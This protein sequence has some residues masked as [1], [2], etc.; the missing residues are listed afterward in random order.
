MTRRRAGFLPWLVL[1]IACAPRQDAQRFEKQTPMRWSEVTARW[2]QTAANPLQGTARLTEITEATGDTL[3]R[4]AYFLWWPG[5]GFRMHTGSRDGRP[6]TP[7]RYHLLGTTLTT[8]VQGV[9]YRESVDP[10]DPLPDYYDGLLIPLALEHPRG[11][12]TAGLAYQTW[13][14]PPSF[15]V[16]LTDRDPQE[17]G[18]Q[19]WTFDDE[20]GLPLRYEMAAHD[21]E[22]EFG[23][24]RTVDWDW[25]PGTALEMA[26]WGLAIRDTALGPEVTRAGE[27][28]WPPGSVGCDGEP[29]SRIRREHFMP[30][31]L[32]GTDATGAPLALTDFAGS[33]VLLDFWYIGCGPCMQSLPFLAQLETAFQAQGLRVLGVNRHQEPETV[34]RYLMKR[35]LHLAQLSPDSSAEAWGVEAYPAWFL[36]DAS[37][38]CVAQGVGF[39]PNDMPAWE[40][41][42]RSIQAQE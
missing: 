3:T 17:N 11:W 18:W 26:D 39:T 16:L 19:M 2:Q 28:D 13:H 35:G 38:Q 36:M 8:Q 15:R 27:G 20:N 24:H 6:D 31:A 33:P 22:A 40:E 41:V 34:E 30:P 21:A 14:I 25:Q 29:E 42:I 10:W 5:E 12:D 1:A 7:P 9:A 32:V 37:G 4:E 23:F